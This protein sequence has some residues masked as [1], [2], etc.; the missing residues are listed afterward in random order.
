[1]TIENLRTKERVANVTEEGWKTLEALNMAQ[2]WRIVSRDEAPVERTKTMPKALI[3]FTEKRNQTA[4]SKP[5]KASKTT[6]A[7][8]PIKK[9]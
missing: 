1:V 7:K 6:K 9:Q 3:D 8:A 4:A 5:K 2:Y